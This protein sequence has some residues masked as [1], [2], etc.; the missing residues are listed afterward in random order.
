[1]S[2]DITLHGATG[3]TGALTADYLGTHLPPGATWAIAGRNRSKL[4]G[5]ADAVSAAGGTTP[6][7]V[8][9]DLQ[10]AAS[11]RAMAEDTRVLISTVGPYL[12]HGL[13]AVR[14]AAE[15]GIGYLDLTGEPQFVDQVWL[16]LHETAERTGARLVH[17]CGFDSIPYDLGALYTVSQLPDD[18]PIQL[19]GYVRGNLGPSGGTYHS[20][21]GQFASFRQSAKIAKQRR[22]KEQRPAD[23]SIRGA[24]SLGRAEHDAGWAVP[25]P[26]V[27]PQIVLRSARALPTYGPEFGYEH[28]AHVKTTRMLAAGA[29]GL[30]VLGVGAQIPPVRS[31]LLRLKSPGDGPSPEERAKAWFTLDFLAESKDVQLHTRVSGRDPGYGGTAQ[32]LSEAA[33]CLAFDDLP[34]VAGQT[35]TAV[36]MGQELID[37]L[38]PEI[39]RFQTI[40]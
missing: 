22:A 36:A 8:V 21:I 26:T 23:R 4:Q 27:D 40:D 39:L 16:D 35:T 5:V 24:G 38:H 33:L 14:A 3:F 19:K 1:M 12:K 30:G 18:V 10:D 13:P 17:A 20:A 29:V 31:L 34:P 28:Y 37:R 32:M 6:E 15:A 7:I 2:V 11:M 9:A 25:L